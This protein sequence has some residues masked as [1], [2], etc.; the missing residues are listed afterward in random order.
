MI[1]RD[2]WEQT[3]NPIKFLKIV[4]Q[5]KIEEVSQN[6]SFLQEYNRM[7]KNFDSY[8]NSSDTWFDKNYP[9]NKEDLIAYFSAEYGL[10]E[11]IPIY[12]GRIRY[13]VRGPLEVC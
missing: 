9:N 7:V 5:E 1:D 2:L 3:K 13:F 8:M 10:D 12:S 11:I 6:D 4:S